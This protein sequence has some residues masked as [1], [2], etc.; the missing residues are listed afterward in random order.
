MNNT[1]NND[2]WCG[3]LSTENQQIATNLTYKF[4]VCRECYTNDDLFTL[5]SFHKSE[6]CPKRKIVNQ[7]YDKEKFQCE[8]KFQHK[9]KFQ[10]EEKF[11][12][13]HLSIE[14]SQICYG[15]NKLDVCDT[16]YE[17]DDYLTQGSFHTNA[18][19][20]LKLKK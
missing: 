10:R 5:G 1:N 19:C 8:E 16:C 20:P 11:L 13:D 9:K 14:N 17:F 3:I 4:N 15:M 7:S 2:N 18:K 6:N 12:C